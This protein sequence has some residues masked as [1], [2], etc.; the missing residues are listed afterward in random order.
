MT[1]PVTG[2]EIV[3]RRSIDREQRVSRRLSRKIII[4]DREKA[5][6]C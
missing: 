4:S 6:V 2:A 1:R 5:F 3:G